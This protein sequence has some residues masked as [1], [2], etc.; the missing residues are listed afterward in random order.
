MPV[1]KTNFPDAFVLPHGSE[2]FAYSTNDGANVPVAVSRNLTDWTVLADPADP[3]RK[4]DAM[5]RL[6]SWAKEGFTWA[7]EVLELNGKYLL[8]YTASARRENSQCVGVAVA[9]DPKGPFVDSNAR[10]DRLP[11]QTRRNDR[12]QPVQGRGRQPL[13]LFQERREPRA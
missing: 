11:D 3:K 2:F 6:G 12:R 10:T 8:Y 9:A 7:P 13:S 5:P 1:L 4:Y